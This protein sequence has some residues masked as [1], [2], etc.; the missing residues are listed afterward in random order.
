MTSGHGQTNALAHGLSGLVN[1]IH[2][3]GIAE[4]SE[5]QMQT[6]ILHKQGWDRRQG[7]Y[8]G[9]PAAMPISGQTTGSDLTA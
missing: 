9:R 3:S 1:G 6:H 8:S 5:T 4:C 2:L 7:Y